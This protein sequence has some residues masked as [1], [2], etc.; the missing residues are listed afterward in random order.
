MGHPTYNNGCPT[1]DYICGVERVG[2]E[3][4]ANPRARVFGE[5]EEGD[6]YE[7]DKSE[8]GMDED[9]VAIAI[10]WCCGGRDAV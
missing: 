5:K 7:H 9:A 8:P 2:R 4:T 10:G 6:G 1:K 3:P